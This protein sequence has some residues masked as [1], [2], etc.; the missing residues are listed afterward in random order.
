MSAVKMIPGEL[1]NKNWVSRNK[2]ARG[3]HQQSYIRQIN[4]IITPYSTQFILDEMLG[5]NKGVL[6][7]PEWHQGR[8]TPAKLTLS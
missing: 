4:E 8:V 1:I 3:Q 6:A 5:Y 7:S 2:R